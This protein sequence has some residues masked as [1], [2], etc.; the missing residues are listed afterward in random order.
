M[1]FQGNLREQDSLTHSGGD[2]AG[3]PHRFPAQSQ[4]PAKDAL[5][6]SLRSLGRCVA[7]CPHT[8]RRR[9]G[10]K[11]APTERYRRIARVRRGERARWVAGGEQRGRRFEGDSRGYN[12]GGRRGLCL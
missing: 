6:L 4:F 3:R 1:D 10:L 8:W 9:A 2:L 7:F 5:S 12:R 11:P